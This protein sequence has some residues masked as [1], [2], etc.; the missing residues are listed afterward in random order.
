MDALVAE[1]SCVDSADNMASVQNTMEVHYISPKNCMDVA[2]QE[3]WVKQNTQHKG[4][5]S[6]YSDLEHL[7]LLNN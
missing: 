1:Q 7:C 5:C 6:G 3:D 4:T 2:E